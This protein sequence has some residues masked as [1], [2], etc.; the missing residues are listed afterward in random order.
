MS[1]KCPDCFRKI[2]PDQIRC[3]CGWTSFTLQQMRVACCYLPCM[4]N[5]IARVWT[6]TGWANVCWPHY[7]K[8]KTAPRRSESLTVRE[9]REAYLKSRHA[10]RGGSLPPEK[11]IGEMLPREPGEDLEESN[12]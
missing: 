6:A 4:E 2:R 1:N 10:K 5:A 8:V 12:P 11:S 7:E 3:V 9:N